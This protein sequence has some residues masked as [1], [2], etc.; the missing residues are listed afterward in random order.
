MS[1]EAWGDEGNVPDNAEDTAMLQDFRDIMQR[2][3]KW[4]RSFTNEAPNDEILGGM[5]SI[6]N[7]LDHFDDLLKESLGP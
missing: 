4:K 2:Y 5:V 6:E 7:T 3:K 1:R